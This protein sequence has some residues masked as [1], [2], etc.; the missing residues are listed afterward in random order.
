[1]PTYLALEPGD[2][3]AER[4][5]EDAKALGRATEASRIAYGNEML[6]LLQVHSKNRSGSSSAAI[7]S[8]KFTELL[9]ASLAQRLQTLPI[10][11]TASGDLGIDGQISHRTEAPAVD[12]LARMR[13]RTPPCLRIS[14]SS[15]VS[16]AVVA[17][18]GSLSPFGRTI[19]TAA[20]APFSFIKRRSRA[21]TSGVLAF[22]EA[23]RQALR[24]TH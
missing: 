13:G 7:A 9:C 19:R 8:L 10:G 3:L 20:P 11:C 14:I 23:M 5:L 2:A 22:E 16:I 15:D 24:A 18:T 21:D 6:E 1:L 17:T 4:G 12:A